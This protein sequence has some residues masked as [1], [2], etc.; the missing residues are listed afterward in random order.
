[1]SA[2]IQTGLWSIDSSSGKTFRQGS[3]VC[4]L[5]D[6]S[7]SFTHYFCDAFVVLCYWLLVPKTIVLETS[8]L[9]CL[10]SGDISSLD[11]L[12][13]FMLAWFAWLNS[14]ARVGNLIF[15]VCFFVLF[16]FMML[17]FHLPFWI[18]V[19]L[20]TG[21]NQTW[22]IWSL[23]HWFLLL[24]WLSRFGSDMGLMFLFFFFYYTHLHNAMMYESLAVQKL[25]WG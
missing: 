20:T 13:N 24:S 2:C 16:Y 6:R 11:V 23:C 17:C 4:T 3:Q 10:L 19:H 12:K 25:L 18:S 1:M 21:W 15:L 7:L 22:D 9:A 14:K 5:C 8:C